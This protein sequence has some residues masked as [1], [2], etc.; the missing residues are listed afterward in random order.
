MLEN[1]RQRK[2]FEAQ[3][4]NGRD[5]DENDYFTYLNMMD[6]DGGSDFS[7]AYD[8]DEDG[9]D[10]F[11]VG[12]DYYYDGEGEEGDWFDGEGE[13]GDDYMDIDD[14]LMWG[15]EDAGDWDDDDGFF[16][17]ESSE[18]ELTPE[19]RALSQLIKQRYAGKS[20]IPLPDFGKN[21]KKDKMQNNN[22]D[23]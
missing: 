11:L 17:N 9:Y 21:N 19:E 16:S 7:D 15:G 18:E 6:N 12:D 10:D 2:R 8:E 1:A 22:K 13:E 4:K 14:L 23:K 5:L 20:A 3:L